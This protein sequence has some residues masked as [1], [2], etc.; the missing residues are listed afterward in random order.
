MK[1]FKIWSQTSG[2]DHTALDVQTGKPYILGYHGSGK[3]YVN[4]EAKI[5]PYVSFE[6]KRHGFSDLFVFNEDCNKIIFHLITDL[7]LT[8]EITSVYRDCVEAKYCTVSILI[9]RVVDT[10]VLKE[11]GF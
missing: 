9:Q 10:W 3:F 4:G 2:Y 8:G 7:S 1:Q 5:L 11:L 6:L